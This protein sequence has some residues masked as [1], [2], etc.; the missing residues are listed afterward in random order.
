LI[1]A[2]RAAQAAGV[3][4]SF[5]VFD[6]GSTD[7]TS[8]MVGELPLD[9][10]LIRG[11]GTAFWANSMAAAEAAAFNKDTFAESD[12]ILWL[13]DDVVLDDDALSRLTECAQ[14]HVGSVVVGSMRDPMSGTVS[15]SGL[16]RGGAHPLRFDRVDPESVAQPVETFNGN[17]VLIPGHVAFRIGGIDG[18]FSHGLADIDY[19][20]RCTR[21][22]IP[23]ILAPGTYGSC[24]RNPS[25]A[26]GSL[27]QE[28]SRFTGLKGGGNFKSLRR[29]LRKGYRKSWLI[30]VSATY[31]LW[32]IREIKSRVGTRTM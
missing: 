1:G 32:W 10:S 28:W 31:S 8:R 25:P 19:G 29:I 13:N 20:L 27:L 17:L 14:N 26:P 2:D 22:G 9:A 4:I 11:D 12:F 6:D 21:A 30:Y 24:P 16:R 3:A 15:Y 23:V 18:G 7:G 5:I